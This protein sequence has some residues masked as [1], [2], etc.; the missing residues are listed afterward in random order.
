MWTLG[1]VRLV[2]ASVLHI[3]R[4]TS[5][6][7]TDRNCIFHPIEWRGTWRAV[8]RNLPGMEVISPKA[9]LGPEG[10]SYNKAPAPVVG[11]QRKSQW[12]RGSAW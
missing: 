12:P 5:G 6:C 11:P 2:R 1:L 7:G 4:Y 10:N 9:H 8:E 3:S